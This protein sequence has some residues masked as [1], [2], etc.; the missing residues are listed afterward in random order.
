MRTITGS[1]NDNT[2]LANTHGSATR[3][4]M[5]AEAD[6]TTETTPPNFNFLNSLNLVDTLRADGRE[7][8][9]LISTPEYLST[10]ADVI[11]VDSNTEDV[12]V[13][14]SERTASF[15]SL[16][17]A[18]RNSHEIASND[19]SNYSFSNIN[20]MSGMVT[21]YIS[22]VWRSAEETVLNSL[23]TLD[24]IRYALLPSIFYNAPID[25]YATLNATDANSETFPS[26]L[27]RYLDEE[28]IFMNKTNVQLSEGI[29]KSSSSIILTDLEESSSDDIGP[30]Y[31]TTELIVN[32]INESYEIDNYTSELE[33][34]TQANRITVINHSSEINTITDNILPDVFQNTKDKNIFNGSFSLSKTEG[35]LME[36]EH[37]QTITLE[38]NGNEQVLSKDDI[39]VHEKELV[40]QETIPG[41]LNF[42]FDSLPTTTEAAE[43]IQF[44]TTKF[45]SE[46]TDDIYISELETT[47]SPFQEISKPQSYFLST[48]DSSSL[49]NLT[50]TEMV[51]LELEASSFISQTSSSLDTNNGNLRVSKPPLP[52]ISFLLASLTNLKDRGNNQVPS[53]LSSLNVLRRS[54]NQS[55]AHTKE[56]LNLTRSVCSSAAKPE[57]PRTSPIKNIL[58]KCA[59]FRLSGLL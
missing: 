37:P 17:T 25:E 2:L 22:S 52:K 11:L 36:G 32:Y 49:T 16:N 27:T 21:S 14:S 47:V 28:E 48:T 10:T 53:I 20:A 19:S 34:S 43:E 8:T 33:S 45:D 13:K 4:N 54:S 29:I 9:S 51:P 39:F 3:Q 12:A 6:A 41:V 38:D 42:E 57:V 35:I 5:K 59:M 40:P 26:N 7:D 18:Q 15:T 31:S 30:N 1:E 50:P 58:Q 24:T 55:F 23:P 56:T 44:T 46:I